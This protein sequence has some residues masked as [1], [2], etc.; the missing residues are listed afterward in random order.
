[1]NDV[2]YEIVLQVPL[3]TNPSAPALHTLLA[4]GDDRASSASG[5]GPNHPSHWHRAQP[6]AD[7][8]MVTH[9]AFAAALAPLAHAHEAEG[10]SS[11]VVPITDL[12]DEFNFGERTP[13]AIREFLQTANQ[14]WK[15]PPSYLLLNG[16]ASFDPRNYLGMG[17]LD[18]VPTEI[19]ASSGLMTASDDWFSDFTNAGMPTIATGRL[20]VGTLD[21][22]KTVLGKIVAYESKSTNGPWTSQALMVADK[23]D[24]ENFTQDSKKVQAQLP[25][26]MKA[27][28]VFAGTVGTAA[29]RQDIIDSI[30]SGQLLVNYMGHGAEE[31]WSGSDIFDTDSVSSLTNGSQLPVFLIMDCLNG[32]FQDVYSQPLGVTLLLAPNGGAVATLASSGLN[33]PA[34]QTRLDKLVVQNALSSDRPTIGE[35]ILKAK[36]QIG[37]ISVRRTYILFGDPAMQIKPPSANSASH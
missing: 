15:K 31:Q 21:E 2:I 19:L 17:N 28:Q 18:L 14:N 32:F 37:D 12:Y 7:I 3:T 26:A 27:T 25:S 23:D 24:T 36:S 4:V 34:P 30:N 20:P 11:A 10:K 33:P 8:A 9:D 1:V 13:Y 5:V 6:G 35:S 29:A 16:R 22:A